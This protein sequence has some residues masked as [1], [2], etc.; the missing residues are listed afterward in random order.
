MPVPDAAVRF[1][2]ANR[3]LTAEALLATR[4]T[5][6]RLNPALLDAS[7]SQYGRRLLSLVTEAQH[8]AAQRGVDYVPQVLAEQGIDVDPL[9]EVQVSPHVGIASDG[10]PL[11]TLLYEPVIRTKQ[12][13]GEGAAI[14]PALA[15]GLSSLE[16]IVATQIMD[17]GRIAS[18]VGVAVIPK[19]GYVRQ[20]VT[21]SCPR[22][23]VLAGKFYRWNAGFARHPRCDCVHIPS[24]ENRAGDYTT[25]PRLAIEKGQVRGLSKAD[26]QAILEDGADVGQVINAHRGIKPG[27]VTTEG[28]T[29]RAFAARRMREAGDTF[30]GVRT[31]RYARTTG[32]R[33][34]P[35]AIYRQA[36]SREEAVELLRRYGYVV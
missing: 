33:L 12:L 20:L 4:S 1:R 5:W 19:V 3:R 31:S 26:T 14:G 34:R 17:A 9:G 30:Q 10:R 16:T 32:A 21:P 18:G 15:S 23:V 28:T 24:T 8:L 25:D 29:R 22:C 27:G 13:V 35:E 11:D 6:R 36:S 7:W 2:A